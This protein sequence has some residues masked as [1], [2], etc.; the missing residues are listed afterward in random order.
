MNLAQSHIFSKGSSQDF[1]VAGAIHV[2]IS[3]VLRRFGRTARQSVLVNR[4]GGFA[5]NVGADY[6]GDVDKLARPI[7]N[8]NDRAEERRYIE[9]GDARRDEHLGGIAGCPGRPYC[10]IL[11]SRLKELTK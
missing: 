6:A 9:A 1:I 11:A 2:A 5:R 7:A 8:P 4:F 3:H 10:N